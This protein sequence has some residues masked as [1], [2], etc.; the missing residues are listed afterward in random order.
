MLILS[1]G[2]LVHLHFTRFPAECR[3]ESGEVLTTWFF[4][5]PLQ[6]QVALLARLSALMGGFQVYPAASCC[7]SCFV[8]ADN[9]VTFSGCLRLPCLSIKDSHPWMTNGL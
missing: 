6:T 7:F 8:V 3:A 9:D 2:L 4:W 5:M 1:F